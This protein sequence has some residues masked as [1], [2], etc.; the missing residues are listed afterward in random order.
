MNIVQITP[1]TAG[2]IRLAQCYNLIGLKLVFDGTSYT[3]I[4]D[5]CPPHEIDQR[6]GFTPI[7]V[8]RG[9]LHWAGADWT[10]F[11]PRDDDAFLMR[12]PLGHPVD[13][14]PWEIH[15]IEDE[16]AYA[17]ARQAFISACH[18]PLP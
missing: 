7:L 9:L 13:G 12:Q 15:R 10:M 5:C 11:I 2:C 1:W 6:E 3:Y 17:A 18:D 4:T 8:E 16:I 14:V